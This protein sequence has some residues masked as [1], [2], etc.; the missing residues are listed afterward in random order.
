[1]REGSEHGAICN[2]I[3]QLRIELLDTILVV[4]LLNDLECL[5]S[6]FGDSVVRNIGRMWT[7]A[8]QA[9][10]QGVGAGAGA[11]PWG[12]VSPFK[13]RYS[14]AYKH[15]S[16]IGLPPLGEILYPPLRTQ[17][18][19][20]GAGAIFFFLYRYWPVG[21]EKSTLRKLFI[22]LQASSVLPHLKTLKKQTSKIQIA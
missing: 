3:G 21:C 15:Q 7:G 18:F 13:M 9:R 8:H 5:P 20:K 1:M 10:I 14:I 19:L 16:I 11:H 12:G 17:D 4:A 2:D 22:M 6:A